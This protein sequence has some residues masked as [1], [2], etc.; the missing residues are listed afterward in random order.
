MSQTNYYDVLGVQENADQDTI[1]KAYRSLAKKHHPDKGG[2]DETF[3]KVSEAYDVLGD[4]NKRQ[5]YDNQRKNPFGDMGSGFNPFGDMFNMFGGQ[6]KRRGAPE[7]VIDIMVTT[8]ESYL[9]SDK[10]ILYKRKHMCGDCNGSGGERN[11]CNVCNG[12]GVVVQKMSNGMMVQMIQTVCNHCNGKGFVYIK[13]CNTCRGNCSVEKNENIKIKLPHGIDDGQFLRLQGKGD[14]HNGIYG[15]LVVRIKVTPENNFEK[16]GNDL[17]YNKFLNLDDIKKESFIL[18]HPNGE[19]SVKFPL[20][21]DSSVPLRVK[22]K[23]FNG[24]ELY[25]KLFV[26]FTR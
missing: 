14:F 25:I 15:N 23:G 16:F 6:Q 17:I 12:S 24:G 9:G 13:T 11:H 21:F 18:P 26:K 2:N 22:S 1:K 10:E 5:H 20:I 4:D 19:L 7:K 3:K 8:I